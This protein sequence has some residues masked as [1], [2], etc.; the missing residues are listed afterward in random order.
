[1][2]FGVKIFQEHF[3]L[4][5]TLDLME[6]KGAKKSHKTRVNLGLFLMKEGQKS[7]VKS[8]FP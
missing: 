8:R 1:M 7:N 3:Q 5:S 2:L 4:Q 6:F